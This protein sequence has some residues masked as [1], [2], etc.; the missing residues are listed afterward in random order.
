M[1]QSMNALRN[2]SV[3]ATDGEIGNLTD[4]YFDDYRWVVRYLIVD[5]GTWLRSRE[6]LISPISLRYETLATD[7]V[8]VSLSKAQ[9]ASSPSI[10][11]DKPV[12]RQN[13]S[14]HLTYYGYPNYWDGVGIWGGGLYPYTLTPGNQFQR[15]N[16]ADREQAEAVFRRKESLAHE[17]DNPHLRSMEE[18]I[19]YQIHTKDGDI[20]HIDDI[21]IDDETWA[22]R[23][24]VLNTSNWWLGHTVLISPQWITDISWSDETISLDLQRDTIKSAPHFQG[25]EQFDREQERAL[26]EH[27]GRHGYWPHTKMVEAK[28]NSWGIE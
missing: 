3:G 28:S 24:F 25:V 8:Y 13:E 10:D 16:R 23:Y 7:T 2:R 19:G 20:G 14:E 18:V 9:V 15:E 17:H 6:V 27:Y 26:F 21:L 11:T 12:S 22:I 5:T 4:L 1:L